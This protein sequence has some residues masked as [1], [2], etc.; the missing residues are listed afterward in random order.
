MNLELDPKATNATHNFESCKASMR[1]LQYNKTTSHL[2]PENQSERFATSSI[3]VED[4]DDLDQEPKEPTGAFSG[5]AATRGG[6][7]QRRRRGTKRK[8]AEDDPTQEERDY[9]ILTLIT[10]KVTETETELQPLNKL[11]QVL[12]DEKKRDRRG[13][14]E[15]ILRTTYSDM[16]NISTCYWTADLLARLWG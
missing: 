5:N 6:R 4:N 10:T 16:D 7:R 1:R 15:T 9:Q 2:I 14:K 8:H 11:F 3:N 12:N 13:S